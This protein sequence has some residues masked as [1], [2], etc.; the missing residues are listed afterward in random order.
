MQIFNKNWKIISENCNFFFKLSNKTRPSRSCRQFVL[1][2]REA[3]RIV[4]FNHIISF[5]FFAKTYEPFFYL[6]QIE[7]VKK[8][9]NVTKY[10]MQQ[11]FKWIWTKLIKCNLNKQEIQIRKKIILYW[12]TKQT[13]K[14]L[15]CIY[16]IYIF[17]TKFL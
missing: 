7:R 11:K 5:I 13:K 15:K 4:N 10:K 3:F 17:C 12:K 1:W 14:T 2:C 8:A 9:K 16:E 6:L